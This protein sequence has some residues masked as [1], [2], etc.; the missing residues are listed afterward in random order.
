MPTIKEIRAAI[1]AGMD[2]AQ[3]RAR[4]AAGHLNLS[5]D[6]IHD[7]ITGIQTELK[8]SAA[9]LQEKMSE[10]GEYAGETAAKI[11][12]ALEHLQVQLALGKAESRD[13]FGEKKKQIQHAIAEFN[14]R[15][16]AADAEEER[17]MSA[18]VDEFL[19]A[20]A[21]QAAALEAELAAMEESYGK[22]EEGS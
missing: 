17:E 21:E 4:A 5:E 11:Q 10:A 8:E 15:L 22:R 13:A 19:R 14:A 2:K 7:R 1:D 6:E 3:A 9:A 18:Q 20:Y 16:D 12:P